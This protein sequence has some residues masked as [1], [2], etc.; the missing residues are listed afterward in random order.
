M[1]RLT[2][3]RTSTGRKSGPKSQALAI[4]A[5]LEPAS[6]LTPP[7]S[8]EESSLGPAGSLSPAGTEAS[9]ATLDEEPEEQLAA[10]GQGA[11]SEDEG[12]AL[13]AL[14]DPPATPSGSMVISGMLPCG[15]YE[16][17]WEELLSSQ[18]SSPTSLASAAAASQIDVA[19]EAAAVAAL[20]VVTL[21][22]ASSPTAPATASATD[23]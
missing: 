8:F 1:P 20:K 15:L 4:G 9:L 7:M 23:S 11:G 13:S 2:A 12:D 14:S 5:D 16:D 22:R 10:V 19:L 17:E 18:S 6:P 3:L 21:Q